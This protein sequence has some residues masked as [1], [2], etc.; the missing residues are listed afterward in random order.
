MKRQIVVELAEKKILDLP[1]TYN[2]HLEIDS[3]LQTSITGERIA[4]NLA[5]ALVTEARSK[6]R[7]AHFILRPYNPGAGEAEYGVA[8]EQIDNLAML[9]RIGGYEVTIEPKKRRPL[10]L[11]RLNLSHLLS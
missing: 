6:D 1:P 11:G 8:S 10:N 3:N 7:G 5:K 4:E 2:A 9:L